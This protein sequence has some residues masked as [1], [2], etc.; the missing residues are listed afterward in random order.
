M[1]LKTQYRIDGLTVAF[2]VRSVTENRLSTTCF[3]GPDKKLAGNFSV[4]RSASEAFKTQ[5]VDWFPGFIDDIRQMLERGESTASYSFDK[6]F[7]VG[8]S[9]TAKISQYQPEDMEYF[10]PNRRSRALRVKTD[11]RDLCAPLTS[12]ITLVYEVRL[13]GNLVGVVIHSIYPGEDIGEL[14]GDVS[15][16]EGIVF[17]DWNHPGQPC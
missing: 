5:D 14:K 11:R 7:N 15:A 8:W 17:F 2:I 13:E 4:F 12:V 3:R 16:R 1:F 10:E 6:G 9:G